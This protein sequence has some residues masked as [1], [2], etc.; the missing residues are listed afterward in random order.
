[1]KQID[2]HLLM[3]VEMKGNGGL[4]A[5]EYARYK[6]HYQHAIKTLNTDSKSIYLNGLTERQWLE[7]YYS[8]SLEKQIDRYEE[9]FRKFLVTGRLGDYHE[10][11]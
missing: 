2:N 3:Q 10:R 4:F 1:M 7:K 9:W 5:H 6:D 8:L 11:N